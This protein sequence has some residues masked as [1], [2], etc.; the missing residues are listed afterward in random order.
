[1]S[2]ELIEVKDVPKVEGAVD[3]VVRLVDD[4]FKVEVR[5]REGIRL[6]E[7]LLLGKSY[8]E[9][10]F[11]VSRMCGVCPIV[12]N[13]TAVQ[14]LE[15]AL[16]AEPY[17][18]A[19]AIREAM[20]I[21]GHLQSHLIH[22]YIFTLPDLVGKRNILEI[23]EEQEKMVK[24]VFRLKK[25]ANHVTD[26]LGGRAVHPI[27]PTVGGLTKYPSKNMLETLLTESILFKKTL[28]EILEPILKAEIP[29]F[30]NKTQYLSL[31]DSE[32]PILRG[33]LSI[34]NEKFFE[35][36]EYENII[37]YT[38]EEYSTARHYLI[39][40]K[41]YMVGALSRVNNN[42]SQLCEK[43][44]E[45]SRKYGISFPSHSPFMNI[46]AQ[47]IEMIHLADKLVNILEELASKPLKEENIEYNVRSGEGISISEAPR[48]VLVHHYKVDEYGK[49]VESNI[50]T[51][52]AQNYKSIEESLQK[53][54]ATLAGESLDKIS[55]EIEKLVRAYDP[56]VSCS[57]RF[58]KEH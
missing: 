15:K 24:T 49:I 16:L 51:P 56:C 26:I 13:I 25:V 3:V 17:E 7:R 33:K 18:D 57:A 41:P 44:K 1:M 12:H 42:Y 37:S 19:K 30:E 6:L 48:G 2:H 53:Y 47:A 27:T 58:L 39:E 8:R 4:H 28:E 11:I 50:I 5:A 23:V 45:Y 32:Y 20:V 14:A 31:H 54:L 9:I 38:N 29:K 35:Q 36:E 40:G 52:T 21:G 22:L 43:A 10:P 34:S 46:K 55:G